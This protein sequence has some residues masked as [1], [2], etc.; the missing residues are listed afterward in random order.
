MIKT[1]VVILTGIVSLAA[2]AAP[3][4]SAGG[5]ADDRSARL[6]EEM[7]ALNESMREA[8]ALLRRHL[9]AQKMQLLMR[10]I[11]IRHESLIALEE[12]LRKSRGEQSSVMQE[13][14][15][16][17]GSL[18]SLDQRIEDDDGLP[19]ARE[20]RMMRSE[21]ES[22]AKSLKDRL[23]EL[24]QKVIDLENELTD[25]RSEIKEWEELIDTAIGLR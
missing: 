4:V 7:A 18:G 24:D 23:Y 22:R 16:L 10:R 8:V 3:A 6:V 5:G 11:E 2:S 21:M 25:R 13:I 9:E 15:Q 1:M 20:W 12:E 19:Q 14:E 17:E